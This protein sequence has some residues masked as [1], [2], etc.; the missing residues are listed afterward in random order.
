MSARYSQCLGFTRSLFI[1]II[2]I[3]IIY[4]FT[5]FSWYVY[6]WT[7]GELQ[8]SGFKFL[9]VALSLWCVMF[10]EQLFL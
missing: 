4:P 10:L 3:I 8:H 7:N 5:S 9:I 6:S 1:I 2:I